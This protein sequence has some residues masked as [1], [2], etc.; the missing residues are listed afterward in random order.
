MNNVAPRMECG[1][2]VL[3][4]QISLT[5][6]SIVATMSSK[7][8]SINYAET[9]KRTM[10]G[11][12]LIFTTKMARSESKPSGSQKTISEASGE[13]FCTIWSTRQVTRRK[14]TRDRKKPGR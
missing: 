1:G 2:Q 3:S 9:L 5:T 7:L 4:A 11:I 8:N 14:T 10:N 13:P 12:G 6:S